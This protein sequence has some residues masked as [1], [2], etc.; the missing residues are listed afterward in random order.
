M[1][2]YKYGQKVQV[3]AYGG[4]VLARRVVGVRN[5]AVL[6]CSEEE[7]QQASAEQRRPS[8]VG[9]PENDVIAKVLELL[10]GQ[11]VV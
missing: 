11:D 6:I 4:K 2:T 10:E 1:K 9:F 7:Y 8:C 5:G 3:R